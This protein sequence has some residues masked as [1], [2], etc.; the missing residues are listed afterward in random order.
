MTAPPR[1]CPCGRTD[2][3]GRV[4]D[5][6][7][8]CGRYLAGEPAPDAEALMRSRYTAYVLH[9][10]AYLLSTWHPRTRPGRLDFDPQ[11]KWLGLAVRG[12]VQADA[13]HAEVHFVARHRHQGR[14]GR[15]QERSRFVREDGRWLYVD[16]DVA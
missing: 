9:D 5:L 1:P 11:L 6:S 10:A 13:D 8:C 15:L 4:P 3:R 7:A 14:G 16:G 12:H 2:A